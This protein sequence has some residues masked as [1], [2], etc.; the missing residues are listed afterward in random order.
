MSLG[1]I[2]IITCL[3]NYN[4]RNNVRPEIFSLGTVLER[5][6]HWNLTAFAS[7]HNARGGIRAA[8]NSGELDLDR[9]CDSF[10]K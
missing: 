1:T 4:I 6:R 7:L 9:A 10:R 2:Y 8:R 5:G 3:C